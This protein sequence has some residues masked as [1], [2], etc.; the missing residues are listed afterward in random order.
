M[1]L[2]NFNSSYINPSDGENKM[3]DVNLKNDKVNFI[4]IILPPSAP[5]FAIF[6]FNLDTPGVLS[7]T[8]VIM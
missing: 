7:K 4:P 8:T 5:Y 6:Y 2:K 3:A 1:R